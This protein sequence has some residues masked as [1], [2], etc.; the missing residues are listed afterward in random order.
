MNDDMSDD[1]K[2]DVGAGLVLDI[3]RVIEG[4][5]CLRDAV[6]GALSRRKIP[7]RHG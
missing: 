3:V 4:V 5:S 6:Y 2:R 1:T 7:L